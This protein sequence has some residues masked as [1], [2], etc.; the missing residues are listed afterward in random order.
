[1]STFWTVVLAYTSQDVSFH[2]LPQEDAR[3]S[4]LDPSL[5]INFHSIILLLTFQFRAFLAWC[6]CWI[7]QHVRDVLRCFG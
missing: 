7:T 2:L 4:I 6:L 3:G 5:N 1:M